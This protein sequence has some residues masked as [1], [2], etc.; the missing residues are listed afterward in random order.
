ME[1][2]RKCKASK[3]TEFRKM[4]KVQ[5]AESQIITS[6]EVYDKEPNDSTCWSKLLKSIMIDSERSPT[7]CRRCGIPFSD[8]EGGHWANG[9]EAHFGSESADGSE[10]FK[11]Q[12]WFRRGQKWPIGREVR[13]SVLKRGRALDRC[14]YRG[15][16][17]M[18]RWV[19]GVIADNHQ[20]RANSPL[21]S[22]SKMR[23]EEKS[24][25]SS[26]IATGFLYQ[27]RPL[28]E[29]RSKVLFLRRKVPS[30]S[31]HA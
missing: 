22:V 20:H 26:K 23:S 16:D 4:L 31:A 15:Q 30:G 28:R 21:S 18:R 17:G 2:I 6:Y 13:I 19:G 11:K 9:R 14:R 8:S 10:N 5:E 7:G 1:V 24:S 12:P 25:S 29:K 3:P 27:I